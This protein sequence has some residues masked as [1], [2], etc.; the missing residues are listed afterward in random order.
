MNSLPAPLPLLTAV[1]AGIALLV[2]PDHLVCASNSGQDWPQFLGPNRNGAYSGSALAS[3]WPKE[4][5]AKLWEKKTGQ[6]FSGPVVAANR[7]ILFHRINEAETV[8]CL[9]ATN[10]QSIWSANYPSGFR[11]EIRAE[12]DGPRSTPLIVGNQVF[13]FGAEGMLNCWNFATGEKIWSIDAK[14]KFGAPNG[15]FGI[16]C[17]PLC[18][19][20][21][22]LLNI[23]GQH[24]AGIVAFD[25]ATGNVLWKA[26]G[27][28]ASYSSP[29]AATIHAKR[30]AFFLT[31]KHLCA[32]EPVSGKMVFE[33]P[34]TP[35]I[36]ASVS[37]ATPLVID[38]LIFISASYGAGAALLRF[39]ESGPEKIWSGDSILSNHYA[40]AVHHNGFL[41]G[42]DGRQEQGCNLRC[43]E[44]KTG[45]VRWSQNSFG[46]GTILLAGEQLLILTE[47]GQLIRA[48]A[49]PAEF[50]PDAQPQILPFMV[51]AYPALAD[52]LFYARSRDKLVCLDLRVG[53]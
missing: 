12:D 20:N 51:R 3:D 26:S 27:D 25:R 48:R 34:W 35:Q 46:A 39:R 10:G 28:E 14:S 33:F 2:C 21:A 1:A 44:L 45:K 47:K 18:E 49:T 36:Q 42:F 7:L 4:G 16:A 15:F 9:N 6:G 17:S 19:G 43:V 31:R 38:D 22:V 53:R 40:T 24:G 11:D 29:M 30:Y 52:G 41:Y 23:G 8:E 32:L 5:P 13:T 50:K 37:A